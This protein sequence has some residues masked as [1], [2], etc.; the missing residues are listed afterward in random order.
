MA[1]DLIVLGRGAELQV[2]SL[3]PQRDRGGRVTDAG[4]GDLHH[5]G[6]AQFDVSASGS[7]VYLLPGGKPAPPALG[8][9]SAGA[10]AIQAMPDLGAAGVAAL[11]T[12]GRLVAWAGPGDGARADIRVGDLDR[13]AVTRV[14]HDGLNSSPVWSP[15]GRRL[16][17]ARRDGAALPTGLDRR[18]DGGRRR[19][20]AP[21]PHHAFPGSISADGRTLAFVV[22]GGDDEA[23][24]LDRRDLGQSPPREVV[25]SAFKRD[26]AGALAGRAAA[27]LPIG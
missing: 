24:R 25:R 20:P 15:D 22:A 11:S 26:G 7:L 3:D 13:G 27:R 14:T 5:R 8:W 10:S 23:R 12:D 6:K 16:Y 19:K 17:F 1:P 9:W 2:V 4:A 21:V 18:R